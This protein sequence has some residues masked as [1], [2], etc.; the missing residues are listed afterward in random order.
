M[1]FQPTCFKERDL[2]R[3]R[4]ECHSVFNLIYK[5]PANQRTSTQL[6]WV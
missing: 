6:I 2:G 1:H 5:I 4:C 3:G